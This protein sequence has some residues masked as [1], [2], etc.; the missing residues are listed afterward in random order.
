MRFRD[1]V[2][3]LIPIGGNKKL[4][5]RKE[6]SS[7]V[8]RFWDS[9]A[10]RPNTDP[11]SVTHR[12]IWQRW[13]EIETICRYVRK[14]DRVLDVGCGNGYSTRIFSER[15]REI[16]GIDYSDTM[17]MR[18]REEN[19]VKGVPSPPKSQFHQCDVLKLDQT[20]FGRFDVAITER[21]LIN[22]AGFEKQKQAIANIASVLKPGGRFIFVEGSAEGR[23]RLNLLRK[24]FGL[25][26]M[27][28]VWHNI[29]FK[30]DETLRYMKRFFTV[31]DRIH[32]G[33]FDF[34]S[35]VVHPLTV[36]PGEPR[37]DA[38]INEV[39]ARLAL[40]LQEFGE[41]SRVLFL[42]LRRK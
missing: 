16:I 9:R 39:A 34:L 27:P 15:C 10:V 31:E 42:V 25:K 3:Q 22:L 33:T 36:S 28:R 38:R 37:Y 5:G 32:F 30:E 40:N 21:C 41:V 26:A 8:R 4:S 29:D 11:S 24:K 19:Q 17:I 18:A 7:K 2:F 14:K 20:M 13:L 23:K 6:A 12:D 1:G 35:R